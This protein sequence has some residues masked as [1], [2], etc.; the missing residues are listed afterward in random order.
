MVA[1]ASQPPMMH[2]R[3]RGRGRRRRGI[4]GRGS[5]GRNNNGR[6]RSR[7]LLVLVLLM[8]PFRRLL[9]L[10][11]LRRPDARIVI[12]TPRVS[13]RQR[14][15]WRCCWRRHLTRLVVIQE[16]PN[17][18]AFPAAARAVAEIGQALQV[19]EEGKGQGASFGHDDA[20]ATRK[21]HQE[22]QGQEEHRREALQVEGGGDWDLGG[23]RKN[24]ADDWLHM[25]SI[26]FLRFG[27]IDRTEPHLEARRRPGGAVA[28]CCMM[29]VCRMM[30]M[31]VMMMA[32]RVRGDA[33]LA[34]DDRKGVV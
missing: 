12:I 4:L 10:G 22:E 28:A 31:M 26:D 19:A 2:V 17:S 29:G 20:P 32:A 24:F 8:G 11:S 18:A 7:V 14:W 16:L 6:G 30:M 25:Q 9:L 5:G 21:Q 3:V 13:P 15:Q 34:P 23:V 27:H 1:I 33:W